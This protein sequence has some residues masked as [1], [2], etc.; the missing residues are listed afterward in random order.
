MPLPII[1]AGA[2]FQGGLGLFQMLRGAGMKAKRPEYQIP[3]EIEQNQA[4]YKNYLNARM[5]GAARAE[6][7]LFKNQGSTLDQIRKGS[8]NGSQLL[9]MI[10]GVQGNTNAGLERLAQLEAQDQANRMQGVAKANQ[11]MAG[12]RD[13]AFDYNQQQPFLDAAQAKSS[14]LGGGLR[15]LYGGVNALGNYFGLRNQTQTQ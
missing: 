4:L 13:K 1:A 5:A 9:S 2:A 12:Y 10:G 7:G 11:I 6:R 3:D 14:L 8:I 15:N